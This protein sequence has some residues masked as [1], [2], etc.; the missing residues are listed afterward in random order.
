[1]LHVALVDRKVLEH[2]CLYYLFAYSVFANVF[3][4]CLD[5]IH[6]RGLVTN[7]S[8]VVRRYVQLASLTSSGTFTSTLIFLI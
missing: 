6:Y 2:A 3:R 7:V 8:T 5:I 4:K 1:M